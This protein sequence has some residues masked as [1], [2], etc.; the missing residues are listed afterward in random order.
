MKKQKN[1]SGMLKKGGDISES[2]QKHKHRRKTTNRYETIKKVIEKI[3]VSE[4]TKERL[5]SA[6]E[7]DID[8]FFNNMTIKG[9]TIE[10]IITILDGLEIEKILE[11]QM[12]ME[13]LS[14]LFKKVID[15]QNKMQQMTIKKIMFGGE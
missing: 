11:I 5:D 13:N 8:K 7:K 3:D 4:R 12:T 14:Y 6:L 9:K 15:D 10:E 2:N 1:F